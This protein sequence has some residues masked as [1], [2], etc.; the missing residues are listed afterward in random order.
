LVSLGA[1]SLGD[2]DSLENA[3]LFVEAIRQ[4]GL[5]AIIQG[6]DS[7]M[8]QLSLPERIFA[9]GP[10]PHSWL[11]PRCAGID[12]H[13]GFGTTAAGFRAGIPQLVIPSIADQF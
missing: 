3:G 12:H 5:R 6:W 7:G 9:A 8:K 1:I 10:L 13:G 4:I 2:E 11:L